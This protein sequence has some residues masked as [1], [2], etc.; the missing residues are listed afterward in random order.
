MQIASGHFPTADAGYPCPGV[1]VNTTLSPT[2]PPLRPKQI[3]AE[4]NKENLS[5]Q[6][7]GHEL[8][9]NVVGSDTSIT[10][11]TPPFPLIF[12]LAHISS[13]FSTLVPLSLN[14]SQRITTD[15]SPS[16][17]PHLVPSHAVCP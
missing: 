10:P 13:P 9:L 3:I 11:Q 17:Q 7:F 5:A 8:D 1:T 16:D 4:F 15:H 2:P 12:P 6:I 14:S